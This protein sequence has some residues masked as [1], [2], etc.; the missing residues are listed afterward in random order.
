MTERPSVVR[1]G[2][3]KE[4]GVEIQADSP[5]SS[6]IDPALEMTRLQFVA[7]DGTAV[8]F[9]IAGVQIESM[10]SRYQGHRQVNVG[11]QLIGCPCFARIVTRDRQAAPDFVGDA[12]E[13]GLVADAPWPEWDPAVAA[14]DVVTIAVQVLGKLRA[15]LELPADADAEELERAALAHE[16]VQRHIAGKTVRKVIVVPGKLVNI[17]AN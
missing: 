14:D 3:T 15:R 16:N 8:E 4:G 5:I 10:T 13:S 12:F 11:A 6:P 1:L 7:V 17:V 9:G 2:V